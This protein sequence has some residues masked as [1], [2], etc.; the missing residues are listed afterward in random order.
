MEYLKIPSYDEYKIISDFDSKFLEY[1]DIFSIAICESLSN[2]YLVAKI[3]LEND[4][5]TC[6]EYESYFNNVLNKKGWGVEIKMKEIHNDYYDYIYEITL[7]PLNL[8]Y[9]FT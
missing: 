1:C 5:F 2:E 4:D 6:L 8:N 7:N 9:S 3:N